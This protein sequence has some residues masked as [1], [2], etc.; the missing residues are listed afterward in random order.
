MSEKVAELVSH[1]KKHGMYYVLRTLLPGAKPTYLHSS[2]YE[3]KEL[4][5]TLDS[6]E[7]TI[8]GANTEEI[9]KKLLMLAEAKN[10]RRDG[11]GKPAKSRKSS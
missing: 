9:I 11:D 2:G 3:V 4:G 10:E 7:Y 6:K 5:F 1:V 8:S